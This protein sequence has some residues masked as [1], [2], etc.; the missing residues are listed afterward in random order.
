MGV[1]PGQLIGDIEEV[2]RRPLSRPLKLEPGVPGGVQGDAGLPGQLLVPPFQQQVGIGDGLGRRVGVPE[3]EALK[4]ARLVAGG[5]VGHHQVYAAGD[6]PAQVIQQLREHTGGILLLQ[7]LTL[8][9][10]CRIHLLLAQQLFQ[11]CIQIGALVVDMAPAVDHGIFQNGGPVAYHVA[12]NG[13]GV[14]LQG[15][16]GSADQQGREGQ[17]SLQQNHQQQGHQQ[18]CN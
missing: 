8:Q 18:K 13:E 1:L 11:G 7:L 15:L 5:V 3:E 2:V 16:P 12:V 14:L 9:K 4:A 10:F 17:Q 6:V